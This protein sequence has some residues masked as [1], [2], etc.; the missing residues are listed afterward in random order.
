MK[1]FYIIGAGAARQ[2]EGAAFFLHR[3]LPDDD[4]S[5]SINNVARNWLNTS[6]HSL[7]PATHSTK[8][9]LTAISK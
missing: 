6:M 8:K 1:I 3:L 2:A 9:F 4:A 7:L 5:G